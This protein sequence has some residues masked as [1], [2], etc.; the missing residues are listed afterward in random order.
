MADAPMPTDPVLRRHWIQGLLRRRGL[1]LRALASQIGVSPQA[2]SAALSAPSARIEEALAR[3]LD[4][5][6]AT[7]FPDRYHG[8]IRIP[9]RRDH[10]TKSTSECSVR[11]G[12]AA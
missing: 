2:V 11:S 7:L 1:T 3:A 12:E 9:I 5:P 8:D 4:M 10:G 6:P